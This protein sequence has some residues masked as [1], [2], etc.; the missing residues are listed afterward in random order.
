[1]TPILLARKSGLRKKETPATALHQQTDRKPQVPP[2]QANPMW[3]PA[4]RL[5]LTGRSLPCVW[6]QTH[7]A[8]I[9]PVQRPPHN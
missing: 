1:M 7:R 5:M 8:S 4:A 9:T 3:V 2:G 6:H